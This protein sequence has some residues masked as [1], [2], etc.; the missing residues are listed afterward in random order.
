[1]PEQPLP[2]R[3]SIID[4]TALIHRVLAAY[5]LPAPVCC[6]LYRRGMSDV[7]HVTCPAGA[8]FLKVYFRPQGPAGDAGAQL[9]R[10][11]RLADLALALR[12]RGVAVTA[13]LAD[14]DGRTVVP[15]AAPEG[16]RYGAL[17]PAV[18]GPAPAEVDLAQSREFG[19]LA[20]RLH[21]AGDELPPDLLPGQRDRRYYVGEPIEIMAPYLAQRLT[22]LAYLDDLGARL[23]VAV[24]RLAGHDAPQWGLCHGDL[25]TGNARY[26]AEGRLTLFDLDGAAYGYRALDIGVY[27]V[28]Y[29]WM[30][31][32]PEVEAAK[33]RF[34]DA[35]LEGYGAVRP[36]TPGELAAAQLCS[37]LRHLE[38]MA[39]TLRDWTP[40]L[41]DGWADRDYWDEQLAWFRAWERA[42]GPL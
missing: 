39:L 3:H 32:S 23:M 31:L 30:D 4:E 9:E 25:H 33:A 40:Y 29:N 5:G 10:L 17:Y 37:P 1:M 15:L 34:W 21:C 42:H 38:L 35:F 2:V 26:D 13:P 24:E 22:D 14:R 12:E 6:R 7:Y 8:Y 18:G 19:A 28:S 36:L 27:H 16:E 41:G 11:R 20:A